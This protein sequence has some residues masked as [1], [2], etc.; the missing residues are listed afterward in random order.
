MKKIAIVCSAIC[1]FWACDSAEEIKRKQYI[2]EGFE[3]YKLN[4]ANC[5][6]ADGTGL[7]K[8]YPPIKNSDYL[9]KNKAAVVAS[10]RYGLADSIVVNGRGYHHAMPAND[11]LTNMEIAEITTFL[12]N[13]WGNEKTITSIADA[14][15]I[16][17]IASQMP[18]K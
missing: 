10:M 9:L 16:L 11:K 18:Q 12:Y 5:H 4:C 13:Q 8:L 3:L 6:Q 1:L 2:A 14:E 15:K 17:S 7:G